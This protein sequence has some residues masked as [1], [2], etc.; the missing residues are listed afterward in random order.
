M[1]TD[2]DL[3]RLKD[4]EF[5]LEAFNEKCPALIARL[6]AADAYIYTLRNSVDGLDVAT[7]EQAWRKTKGNASTGA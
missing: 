7:A 2:D 3:R 5:T 4:G 1:F 6:E